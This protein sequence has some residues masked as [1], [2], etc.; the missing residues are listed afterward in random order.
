[1]WSPVQKNK[2]ITI[3]DI[4]KKINV[5]PSTISRVLGNSDYPVSHELR[6]KVLKAAKEMNYH[7]NLW[8][9]NLKKKNSRNIGIVLPSI[10]NPF[11][12][13]VVR[14]IEDV[15]YENDYTLFICSGDRNKEREKNYIKYL[16]ENFARGIITIFTDPT[17][18]GINDFVNQGGV[19]LSIHGEKLDNPQICGFYFDKN[20]EGYIAT[21]HL[22]DLGHK[23]IAFLTAPLTNPLRIHKIEGYKRA[24]VEAGIAINEEYIYIASREYD[25][26]YM[27]NVYDCQVGLEL[28]RQLLLK[29][30]EV[31]AILCMNDIMAL[32][33]ISELQNQGYKIP[34]DYSVVG[35]DDSFF[36]NLIKPKITTVRF[37]K[38]NIGRLAMQMLNDIIEGKQ[39]IKQHNFSNYAHLE[40]RESSGKPR[41]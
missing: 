33:C 14:G 1:M 37:E 22:I 36:S 10:S 23:K 2:R 24:L 34:E 19:V 11:Y 40:I 12:P 32:G 4:A 35:F 41:Y 25:V 29:N 15:A 17:T 28:T 21:R 13:S 30:P 27:D 26:D 3:Y 16:M 5:S 9:R 7:P 39:Q 38:Y 6:E 20:R 31:T 18:D 8:A